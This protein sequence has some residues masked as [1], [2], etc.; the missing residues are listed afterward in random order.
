MFPVRAFVVAAAMLVST[1]SSAQ[2]SGLYVFG[3]SLSDPGNLA[4]AIGADPAQVIT[5]NG[6]IPDHPYAS[7]QFS[8]G[9]VW[10]K[11]YAIA[12]GLGS[13]GLPFSVGGGNFAFGGARVTTDGPGLPPSL[14]IQEGALFLAAHGGV[15]PSD[16]LYVIEGGGND[17]R[18]TLAAA[19]GAADPS[20]PIGAAALAYA[21]D[22]GN[23]VDQLQASGAQH[24][25]V[26][27]VP[28][29]GLAPAVTTLG[30]G[31][32][33]LGSF[34]S[35]SMNSALSMRLAGEAGVT[36]FDVFGTIH[37]FVS[38]P[39]AFDLVNVTDAC[40]A[41]VGCDPSTSL[42]WDGIHPTSA[43]HA[44][45]AREMFAATV[46]EPAEYV[47]LLAG[48]LAMSRRVHRRR[49]ER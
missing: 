13:F 22:M 46:P 47:L 1:A 7:L 15:A 29:L 2:Y 41:I 43:G 3:D 36:I 23:L 25:V 28:D 40:G 30:L 45:L 17:A 20:T 11:T 37:S 10:A 21:T 42:F 9:D 24:I 26:W 34:V 38:S 18:D 12:I 32:S 35:Q 33:F 16:A 6:Y 4:G 49:R 14:T 48:L 31:A 19:A 27:N 8:N 5:G 44:L 39:G